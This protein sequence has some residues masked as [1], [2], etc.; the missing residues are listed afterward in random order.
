[1]VGGNKG[2]TSEKNKTQKQKTKTI[3]TPL[4]RTLKMSANG[5]VNGVVFW[6]RADKCKLDVPSLL[7]FFLFIGC[8]SDASLWPSAVKW[9]TKVAAAAAAAEAATETLELNCSGKMS[10]ICAMDIVVV[11]VVGS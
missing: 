9:R 4:E 10:P 3:K 8:P 11:V 6:K 5:C 1:M 7:F 2:K